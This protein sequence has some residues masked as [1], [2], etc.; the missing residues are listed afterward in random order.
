MGHVTGDEKYECS[1]LNGVIRRSNI[2]VGIVH[3][4]RLSGSFF[5]I[6]I[7]EGSMCKGEAMMVSSL[8][9]LCC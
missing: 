3:W 1:I 2:E 9:V 6:Y 4:A 8:M 7:L 5:G